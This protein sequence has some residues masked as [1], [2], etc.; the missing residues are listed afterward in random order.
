MDSVCE[1]CFFFKGQNSP[2]ERE[3]CARL[4]EGGGG[5]VEGTGLKKGDSRHS[6]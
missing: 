6:R 1:K 2:P 5:N 4:E 3:N